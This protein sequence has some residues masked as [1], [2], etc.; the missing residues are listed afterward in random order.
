MAVPAGTGDRYAVRRLGLRPLARLFSYAH[1]GVEPALMGLGPIPAS[2]KALAKVGLVVSSLDVIDS[3]EDFA[4]QVCE[5]AR[6]LALDP[7]GKPERLGYLV[8]PSGRSHRGNHR[9]GNS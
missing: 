1:A 4:A 6:E 2:R 9:Q 7:E 8:G 3:N 5:V